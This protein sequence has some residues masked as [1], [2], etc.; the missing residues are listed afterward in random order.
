MADSDTSGMG[1]ALAAR[2]AIDGR[3]SEEAREYLRKKNRIADLQIEDLERENAIRHWS[4]LV[5]HTSDILKLALELAAAFIFVSVV[6]AIVAAIW[7]ASHDDSLVIDAFK[8][9]QGMAARGL[10]GDVVASELLDRLTDMQ[11]RTDSSRAATTYTSDWGND[12]KV[13]IPN[14]GVSIGEAYRY[15]VGWLGHQTHI[16]GEVFQT[17]KGI[18]LNVRVSG[19]AAIEVD[20]HEPDLGAMLT[21]A[22]EGVYR[23]TQPYRYAIYLVSRGRLAEQA[24][25]LGD[26]AVNGSKEDRPWAYS[27]WA[28]EAMNR[29]DYREML[30]RAQKAVEL[31]PLLGDAQNNLALF[32]GQMNHPEQMIAASRAAAYDFT[33]PGAQFSS[34]T[35]ANVITLESRANIDEAL[36]DYADAIAQYGKASNAQDFEGSHWLSTRMAAADA[37]RAHDVAKSQQLLAG[38]PDSNLLILCC[39]GFG[40]QPPS[41]DMPQFEQYVAMG[42]WHGALTDLK[43]MLSAPH[44]AAATPAGGAVVYPAIA[45]KVWPMLALAEAKTGDVA[46][47]RTTLNR[48]PLD[49]YTCLIVRGQVAA[50]NHNRKQANGWFSRAVALAPSIPF[51][52]ADCGEALLAMH[53]YDGAVAEFTL[54]NQKGPRFADPLEMWGEALIAKN[55][56]DLASARFAEAS[57]YAPKWGRLHLKW[58]EALFWSGD[59]SGAQKQ[60]AIASGLDLSEGEK[61]EWKRM[62]GTHV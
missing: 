40:W 39:T 17:D 19:R 28:F 14:T 61:S 55:R 58:G 25:V 45:T 9:P 57:K 10:G 24:A 5:H 21:R 27:V 56:S 6:V 53:D 34:P 46:A 59:K 60:F 36:G 44:A 22:A 13:E 35:A 8:V 4:L 52:Y 18:T 11:S 12:I 23:Q 33:G 7:M 32:Q 43:A 29:G 49:C 42:D 31:E 41:F 15:L 30:R 38:T 20:G 54:A 3:A 26:L 51:A 50:M 2:L 48:T 47:A 37:A 1:D 16:S 62:A